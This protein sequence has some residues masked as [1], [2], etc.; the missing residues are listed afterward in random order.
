[1]DN[2]AREP[3]GAVQEVGAEPVLEVV[4][5]PADPQ[6][7]PAEPH[8]PPP[9]PPSS[10][11]PA[12]QPP[13]KPAVA[14][15]DEDEA[16]EEALVLLERGRSLLGGGSWFSWLFAIPRQCV[17]GGAGIVG[18]GDQRLARLRNKLTQRHEHERELLR[19]QYRIAGRA[20]LLDRAGL[21]IMRL[22]SLFKCDVTRMSSALRAQVAA[23]IV[24]S[25]VVRNTMLQL[26]SHQQQRSLHQQM[27]QSSRVLGT[28][29]HLEP[30]AELQQAANR[31]SN[32]VRGRDTQV[33]LFMNLVSDLKTRGVEIDVTA[34]DV[35]GLV[36]SIMTPQIAQ[37]MLGE[38]EFLDMTRNLLP[39]SSVSSQPS[40]AFASHEID[41]IV[42]GAI[43][44]QPART[45]A[46]PPK[47][48]AVA[49]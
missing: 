27:L 49:N 33:E 23:Y 2:P 30:L 32:L 41:S 24:E 21:N 44:A 14:D 28:T 9:P 48:E 19:T 38:Q 12:H 42:S 25:A 15:E 35:R 6:P 26:R 29:E 10:S 3:Q 5:I 4:S 13:R 34:D 36:T 11:A 8:Q 16:D 47:R 39:A 18:G 40:P 20:R 22:V 17:F 7:Q 46:A 37:R 43:R 31:Y 45:V 1:M